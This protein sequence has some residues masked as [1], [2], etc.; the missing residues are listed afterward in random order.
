MN[1]DRIDHYFSDEDNSDGYSSDHFVVEILVISDRAE[2]RSKIMERI[3]NEQGKT[4]RDSAIQSS[5]VHIVQ[6]RDDFDLLDILAVGQMENYRARGVIQEL[7]SDQYGTTL[8][9]LDQLIK[10]GHVTSIRSEMILRCV[11]CEIWAGN[12]TDREGHIL[13]PWFREE[14]LRLIRLADTSEDD[15]LAIDA[16]M[17]LRE[18]A[19]AV[20]NHYNIAGIQWL[21]RLVTSNSEHTTLFGAR[22]RKGNLIREQIVAPISSS[23]LIGNRHD[24]P[25][26]WL[27]SQGYRFPG[28]FSKKLLVEAI[29]RN[30]ADVASLII[31][32]WHVEPQFDMIGVFH[33]TRSRNNTH[34]GYT[35]FWQD[36]LR[37][38]ELDPSSCSIVHNQSTAVLDPII[39]S[40][41][42]EQLT[43]ILDRYTATTDHRGCYCAGPDRP[44]IHLD[45]ITIHDDSYCVLISIIDHIQ[46][47]DGRSEAIRILQEYMIRHDQP[48]QYRVSGRLVIIS[49]SPSLTSVQR[50]I[51]KIT[52][53]QSLGI[54]VMI[55]GLPIAS[56]SLDRAVITEQDV[57]AACQN[58]FAKS[59]MSCV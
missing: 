42:L 26:L 30:Q 3:H 29:R 46:D 50:R 40:G 58:I 52:L 2:S 10:E 39:R 33:A 11:S 23:E 36:Y 47:A 35:P 53:V 6:H 24:D 12:G 45:P 14:L 48:I 38:A 59:A 55:H 15:P 28:L 21:H 4:D 49:H 1:I 44:P 43:Q 37:I 22:V 34:H 8:V 31:E 7:T 16:A 5:I 9:T 41:Q 51:H 13:M 54:S 56:I 17:V 25:L 32:Q 20:V 19:W 27:V 57:I 18:H